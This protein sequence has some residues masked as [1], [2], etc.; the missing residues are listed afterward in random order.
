MKA[1][2]YLASHFFNDAFYQWTENLARYIEARVPVDLYVPQRN[3]EINNKKEN[4]ASITDIEIAKQDI[5]ALEEAD[6]LIANL[7]GVTIDDGVAGEIMAMSVMKTR[8]ERKKNGRKRLIIGVLT[9]MRWL[10]TGENKIYRNQ[11]ILGTVKKDGY[12]IVGYPGEKDY[13]DELINKMEFFLKENG[14]LNCCQ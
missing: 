11:M 7:D 6:I 4:D 9:D 2:A 14:F 5:R 10:G 8:D 13:Y 12:L 3:D 1:K